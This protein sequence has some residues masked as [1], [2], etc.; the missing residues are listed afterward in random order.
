MGQVVGY[1]GSSTLNS[2]RIRVSLEREAAL[3]EDLRLRQKVSTLS[4]KTDGQGL[5][6][7]ALQSVH[8]DLN[9]LLAAYFELVLMSY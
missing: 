2:L 5:T 8:V 6:L 3:A 7:H 1:I 4:T 9:C